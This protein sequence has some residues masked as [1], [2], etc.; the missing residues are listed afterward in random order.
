MAG[1]LL[2]Q[3]NGAGLLNVAGASHPAPVT[4]EEDLICQLSLP[5]VTTSRYR[6][7]LTKPGGSDSVLS[8]TT[9]AGPSF[10]PDVEGGAYS[11]SCFDINENEYIL[12]IVTPTA[13]VSP[14][15]GGS[16]TTSIATY[17]D[18]RAASAFGSEPSAVIL[19]QCRETVDDGGG[20]LFAYDPDDTTTADN[21]G[22]VLV[23]AAGERFKRVYSGAI[24]ARWFGVIDDAVFGT[25]AILIEDD[26]TV[27]ASL[28]AFT[29][30]DIGKL[31]FLGV[32]TPGTEGTG[33]IDVTQFST[34]VTGTGTA[35]LTELYPGA[36]L[37]YKDADASTPTQSVTLLVVKSIESDTS[38]T[39]WQGTVFHTKTGRTWYRTNGWLTTIA[40]VNSATS[41]ELAAP[42]P[43]RWTVGGNPVVIYVY[44]SDSRAA[45]L[46]AIAATPAGGAC[47]IPAGRYLFSSSIPLGSKSI[48]LRG[49]STA[50]LQTG[51]SYCGGPA[52]ITAASTTDGAV[53]IFGGSHGIV[54]SGPCTIANLCLVGPGSHGYH[55]VYMDEDPGGSIGVRVHHVMAANFQRGMAIAGAIDCRTVTFKAV[56]CAEG[57]IVCGERVVDGDM[58]CIDN[59]FFDIDIQLCGSGGKFHQATNV[60]FIGGILQSNLSDWHL[61]PFDSDPGGGIGGVDGILVQGLYEEANLHTLWF[62]RQHGQGG[63]C[64]NLKFEDVTFGNGDGVSAEV[65][66][67]G[68]PGVYAIMGGL[69]FRKCGMGGIKFLFPDDMSWANVDWDDG[70]DLSAT[71]DRIEIEDATLVTGVNILGSDGKSLSSPY[72]SMLPATGTMTPNWTS[73]WGTTNWWQITGVTTIAAPINACIGARIAFLLE[74]T[75]HAVSWNA[76]YINP[77]AVAED[78]VTYIEFETP[79]GISWYPVNAGLAARS[80][81]GGTGTPEGA[82]TAPVGTIWMRDDGGSSQAPYAKVSGVGNTGWENVYTAPY[83][84]NLTRVHRGMPLFSDTTQWSFDEYLRFTCGSITGEAIYF[85]LDMPTGVTISDIE[86]TVIGGGNAN[87]PAV[88]P[89]FRLRR[90]FIASDTNDSSSDAVDAS[91]DVTAYNAIH[92][93]TLSGLAYSVSN[94]TKYVVEFVTESGANAMAG[95]TVI[96][97]RVTM[98]AFLN[99]L[100]RGSA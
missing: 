100:D 57:G 22:T 56:G 21:D 68:W 27:T 43:V 38:L 39:V 61:A 60:R 89:R 76:A 52:N 96:G 46:A 31:I 10:I 54:T 84:S 90:H 32:P 65:I 48:E 49:P 50:W 5:G 15:S 47:E 17:G 34:T 78:A 74:R 99:Q 13:G 25:N 94:S 30:D 45:L 2:N 33:T 23:G 28:G 53:L 95:F 69:H 72:T 64:R 44:G 6:W 41:I 26:A 63:I 36:V 82:V 75:T 85:H 98:T 7:V 88:M 55:G 71:T 19:I 77:P 80:F 92:T 16:I 79:D 58:S 87:L 66:R 24:D 67:L 83:E 93:I 97:V 9:S 12:D 14:G 4:V 91:A 86:V 1:I 62:D 81:I 40:D 37:A 3:P 18:V 20:G 29:D 11:I 73:R 70:C 51:F 59:D 42:S 35:F 8:S